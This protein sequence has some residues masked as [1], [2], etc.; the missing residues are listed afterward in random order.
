MSVHMETHQPDA[1][2]RTR[3]LY[4]DAECMEIALKAN[5]LTSVLSGDHTPEK[6]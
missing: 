4:P 5:K 2:C 6:R 3:M 1:G